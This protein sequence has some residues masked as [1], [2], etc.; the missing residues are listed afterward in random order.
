MPE[1]GISP[2]TQVLFIQLPLMLRKVSYLTH[3][4]KSQRSAALVA[5]RYR[6]RIRERIT[7]VVSPHLVAAEA[8]ELALFTPKTMPITSNTTTKLRLH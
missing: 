8:L 5:D 7:A 4:A 3:A 2:N 1:Y 6:V